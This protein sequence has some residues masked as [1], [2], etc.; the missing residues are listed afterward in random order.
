[1]KTSVLTGDVIGSRKTLNARKWLKPLKET[2]QTF[3]KSPRQ[4]EIFRGDS[5]QLEISD[6]ADA[7]SSA[8]LL[9]AILKTVP[10]TDVRIGI[11][12]G[13]KS[14]SPRRI[15]EA[16]G[17]A[18]QRSGS[19]F[20]ALH[21]Q[22]RALA[23]DSGQEELDDELNTLI[24]LGLALIDKWKPATAELVAAAIVHPAK[25]QQEIAELLNISQS[26]VS[27]GL[28]RAH[29]HLIEELDALYRKKI[30]AILNT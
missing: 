25:S 19:C 26:S 27:S 8:I 13:E 11:G 18:F 20:E 6:P 4:W 22:K 7:L 23:V 3:G 28:K 15:T 14:H 2:L 17:T 29:F 5:F 16:N 30:S 1:M 10:Q 21:K 12:I 24:H 9:K